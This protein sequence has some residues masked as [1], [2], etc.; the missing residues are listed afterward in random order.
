L[1]AATRI[2]PSPAFSG[3]RK[4]NE[5]TYEKTEKEKFIMCMYIRPCLVPHPKIR[6]R[7]KKIKQKKKDKERKKLK[8]KGKKKSENLYIEKRERKK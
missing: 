3:E 4:K 2:D 8:K 5:K 1:P 7:N 6:Q